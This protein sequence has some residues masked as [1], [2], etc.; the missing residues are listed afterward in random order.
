MLTEVVHT[1]PLTRRVDICE[2]LIK[3][4]WEMVKMGLCNMDWKTDN[5]F[6]IDDKQIRIFD[7]DQVVTNTGDCTGR[8]TYRYM[9]PELK[10][11]AQTHPNALSCS[12]YALG[13]TLYTIMV[14]QF[15]GQMHEKKLRELVEENMEQDEGTRIRKLV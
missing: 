6:V 5:V 4:H 7:F 12:V 1:M 8:G 15:P 9:A 14:L 13:V 11:S 10:M 2:T 3:F